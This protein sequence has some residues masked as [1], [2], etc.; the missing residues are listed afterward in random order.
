[1]NKKKSLK[2]NRE[3]EGDWKGRKKL[4]NDFFFAFIISCDDIEAKW[5]A[6]KYFDNFLLKSF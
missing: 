2:R 6:S 4:F 5:G 1:M 3:G